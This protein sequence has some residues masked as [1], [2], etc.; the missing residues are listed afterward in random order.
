MWEV[1]SG[2]WEVGGGRWGV[3]AERADE[4][5]GKWEVGGGMWEV[6]GTDRQRSEVRSQGK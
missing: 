6:G 1:G 4:E 2:M 3:I 5:G